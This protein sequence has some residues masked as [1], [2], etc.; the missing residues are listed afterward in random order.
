M[1]ALRVQNMAAA[2]SHTHE[3]LSCRRRLPDE[4]RD[5]VYEFLSP[6]DVL[7]LSAASKKLRKQLTQHSLWAEMYFV[8][9]LLLHQCWAAHHVIQKTCCYRF[10]DK[11]YTENV[12]RIFLSCFHREKHAR[13][14]DAVQV[15]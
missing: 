4:V 14:G 2:A 3:W 13:I 9:Y 6:L 1:R 8:R 15:R 5:R 11:E 10:G 7:V 12:N